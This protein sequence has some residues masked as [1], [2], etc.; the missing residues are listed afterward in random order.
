MA[1][2]NLGLY[3][4]KAVTMEKTHNLIYLGPSGSYTEIAAEYILKQKS[5]EHFN[6]E[7][8]N[9]IL[10][11]I[12]AIDNLNGSIGV[13][14]I[15]NSIEGVV[16]ETVDNL[17]K[18]TSRVMIDYEVVVPISHCLISKSGNPDKVENIVSISQ[19]L[20]QCLHFME[21]NYPKA[22]RL[23]A[24]STS[25]A[26]KNL[27]ELPDNYAAIGSEK[28]AELYGL[29]IIARG[30]ND[31]KDNFTRFVSLA[32]CTPARTGNDKT[33]IAISTA[34]RS[35]ALVDVLSV[36]RE[37][38]INLSYIESRPSKKVFGDYTFFIDFDGHIEDE[39]VQRTLGRITP[40]VNFYRLLGSYPKGKVISPVGE[41]I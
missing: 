9:S 33:S 15:E 38:N 1:S 5:I 11:V 29:K 34:N 32:S 28:A 27:L 17:I 22:E 31:E 24:K 10:G 12:E 18:T 39:N 19:A 4:N 41:K 30:I 16:R 23:Q 8:K 6:R 35:G 14:P 21:R 7:I 20:C 3:Y 26:V 40:F 2:G 36:F 37:N 25:E 13:V